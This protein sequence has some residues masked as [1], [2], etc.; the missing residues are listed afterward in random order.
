MREQR[1]P[2]FL[3]VTPWSAFFCAESFA[4]QQLWKQAKKLELFLS[5]AAIFGQLSIET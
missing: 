5:S 2:Q 1:I 3:F 4:G